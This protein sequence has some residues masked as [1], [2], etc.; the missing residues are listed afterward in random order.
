MRLDREAEPRRQTRGAEDRVG[1]SMKLRSCSTRTDA[2]GQVHLAARRMCSVP[3]S[4]SSARALMEKSRRRRSSSPPGRHRRKRTG[5]AVPLFPRRGDVDLGVAGRRDLVGEKLWERTDASFDPLGQRT[6]QCG[7]TGL[8]REVDV[9][10]RTAQDDVADGP[11]DE[12]RVAVLL[13]GDLFDEVEGALLRGGKVLE[14]VH[15]VRF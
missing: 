14:K 2:A 8:E 9:H 10:R 4:R 7:G 11:T 6:R 13:R 3:S 15:R 1:S 12:E 5:L